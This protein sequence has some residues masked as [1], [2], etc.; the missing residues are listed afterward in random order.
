MK[1][2]DVYS[3]NNKKIKNSTVLLSKSKLFCQACFEIFQIN[4]Y[5]LLNF[6][7]ESKILRKMTKNYKN[8]IQNQRDQ[9][10]L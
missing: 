7:V 6:L 4:F 9:L 10:H 8:I 2:T 1:N 5:V 3:L